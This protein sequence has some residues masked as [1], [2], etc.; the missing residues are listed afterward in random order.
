MIPHKSHDQRF[1]TKTVYEELSRKNF[2]NW[3]PSLDINNIFEGKLNSH[4]YHEKEKTPKIPN[5]YANDSFNESRKNCDSEE[6]SIQTDRKRITKSVFCK[7]KGSVTARDE[8]TVKE[9]LAIPK[10]FE[11]RHKFFR[12]TSMLLHKGSI[13]Q[14]PGTNS[15]IKQQY[16]Q[17]KSSDKN[18]SKTEKKSNMIEERTANY[19]RN[20]QLL[21]QPKFKGGQRPAKDIRE[22]EGPSSQ[23]Q[24]QS[25]GQTGHGWTHSNHPTT[26]LFDNSIKS[27]YLKGHLDIPKHTQE[28]LK[29][30]STGSSW[31][32]NQSPKIRALGTPQK[33]N[34]FASTQQSHFA[35][36]EHDPT[37]L[38]RAR[39][40]SIHNK[41]TDEQE[42]ENT[43]EAPIPVKKFSQFG[44]LM[45]D[46]GYDLEQVNYKR[47]GLAEG[48]V[49]M[50][51][52]INPD[53]YKRFRAIKS[54]SISQIRSQIPVYSEKR[55]ESE[56][57]DNSTM[58][59]SLN[60]GENFE[61]LKNLTEKLKKDKN[62]PYPDR[63]HWKMRDMRK[64]DFFHNY[65]INVSEPKTLIEEPV[66][67][68][69]TRI[70]TGKHLSGFFA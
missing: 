31:Y 30:N 29:F 42:Q 12:N 23:L 27:I 21:D 16:N 52:N 45:R 17:L 46:L 47:K 41:L 68:Q 13:I 49:K 66:K 6:S 40:S 15:F 43:S 35:S 26:G 22:L 7:D 70:Y 32:K 38:T 20:S 59:Q 1:I 33:L 67:L 37:K 8:L 28:N 64:S 63:H 62:V 18:V 14:G 58:S 34:H 65:R 36:T 5:L 69:S 44:Q 4:N 10:N 61:R 11:E 51:T 60:N 54:L 25:F 19:E 39:L 3:D 24:R 2:E 48:L 56:G 9:P 53:Y 57:S 55:K 50:I